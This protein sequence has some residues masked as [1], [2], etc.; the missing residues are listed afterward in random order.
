[1]L[2]IPGYSIERE[3]GRG[4]M[5][6]VHLAVQ[7]KFGRLVAIKIVSPQTADLDDAGARFVREARIVAQLSHSGIVQVHDAG[8]QDDCYYLVMEYLRGG[9]LNRRLERGMHMQAVVAVVRDIARA[10][11]Y[12]HSKGYV[13]RDIKPENILFREDGSAVLSDFGIAQL[14]SG[15]AE[16]ARDG[17]VVGTPQYMSPEQ[18]AGRSL[19]GR[20]DIY[21]LGVV[22]Y[23]MLTGD[24]PYQAD[25]AM[26]VGVKHVQEPIPRLPG[27]LSEF[28]PVLDRFLAKR[29]EN[30][31][32][33]GAEVIAA[34]DQLRTD[35]RVPNSV[36]R[37]QVVT[38]AEVQAVSDLMALDDPRALRPAIRERDR[39]PNRTRRMRVAIA[40]VAAVVVLGG[41]WLYPDRERALEQVLYATGLVEDPELQDA[42]RAAQSLRRDPNQGL[43]TVVAG[44]KRVLAL[45]PDHERARLQLDSLSAQW[46][47][48]IAGLLAA[49]ELGLAE[50]RLN[51]AL[52]AFPTD[53]NLSALFDVVANRKRAESLAASTEALLRSRGL[54]DLPSATTA[55][56]AYREVLRLDQSNRIAHRDLDRLAGH[57]AELAATAAE[58]ANVTLAMS[59]LQLAASANSDFPRLAT[60]RQ[61]IRRATTVQ[62]EIGT[63]LEK[64]HAFRTDG[65]LLDP[66]DENAAELYRR[67]LATD[68]GNDLAK[69][70]LEQIATE[71]LR[72][73][74]ALIEAGRIDDVRHLVARARE[75]GLDEAV[76]EELNASLDSEVDRRN[77]VARLLTEA[78]TL[79]SDGFITAPDDRNAVTR[80]SRVLRLDPGNSEATAMMRSA[81]ERL[82]EVA[83][84]AHAAGL[85][86][87]ARF[88]LE[89]ALTVQPRVQAWRALL[90]TWDRDGAS[91][92]SPPGPGQPAAGIDGEVL[93]G[94]SAD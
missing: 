14:F 34:L 49:D 78:R 92:A 17:K 27:Y 31:F 6:S 59:Y 33:S 48:D 83:E 35:G 55:I 39:S 2:Q 12:A 65:A 86:D 10:L 91:R 61:T 50:A 72:R 18:A 36:I 63:L 29:P 30:R 15:G 75:V 37:T 1:M 93:P 41:L 51:E 9:D 20:S 32:Q 13:H 16:S 7:R 69:Q 62:S 77:E 68:P 53:E 84:Q 70:G 76:Q 19:D 57:Y 79:L 94:L 42:W 82:V 3:I 43:S 24:V 38:T 56:Q 5:A 89:L 90:E 87:E 4:G 47:E 21:S 66:P 40:A 88:Y 60:V 73:A 74:G 25:T 46:Y 81:A 44:Y 45:N 11:D 58:Q 67:V 26:A 71:I 52:S 80:L 22:F 28:Q 64:A 54:D 85:D 23:R 8:V